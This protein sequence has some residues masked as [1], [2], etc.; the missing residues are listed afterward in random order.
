MSESEIDKARVLP[1][2]GQ[3]SAGNDLL[4]AGRSADSPN[5]CN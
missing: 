2:P 3:L 4:C 5:T 1:Q